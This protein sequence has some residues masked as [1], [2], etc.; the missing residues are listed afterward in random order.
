[1]QTE[2]RTVN[3][4]LASVFMHLTNIH[5]CC[6]CVI[7][8]SMSPHFIFSQFF[9]VSFLFGCLVYGSLIHAYCTSAKKSF[10]K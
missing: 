6:C 3:D 9:S 2:H 7:V 4:L 8:N 1:M 10:R 5:M